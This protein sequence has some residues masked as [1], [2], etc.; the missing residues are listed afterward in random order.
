MFDH[1]RNI[2]LLDRVL[3]SVDVPMELNGLLRLSAGDSV[4]EHQRA[5]DLKDRHAPGAIV[6]SSA[7]VT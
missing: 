2:H 6:V 4:I 1:V 5:E 3:R 7:S